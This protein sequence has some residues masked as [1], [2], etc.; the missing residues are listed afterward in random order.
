MTRVTNIVTKPRGAVWPFRSRVSYNLHRRK[1]ARARRRHLGAWIPGCHLYLH[2][3]VT[4]YLYTRHRARGYGYH[5]MQPPA[6]AATVPAACPARCRTRILPAAHTT[7][8]RLP[9]ASA[10][11]TFTPPQNTLRPLRPPYHTPPCTLLVIATTF[12]HPSYTTTQLPLPRDTAHTTH[13][14]HARI[15]THC[16]ARRTHIRTRTRFTTPTHYHLPHTGFLPTRDT[17]HHTTCH[18]SLGSHA[19]R[20]VSRCHV[21]ILP[22]ALRAARHARSPRGPP[23]PAPRVP[24]NTTPARGCCF[25]RIRDQLILLTG[26]VNALS[27]VPLPRNAAFLRARVPHLPPFA[28]PHVYTMLYSALPPLSPR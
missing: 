21:A 25:T 19:D 27:F 4:A 1:P 17:C 10:A 20:V 23:P 18:T 11:T 9:H 16:R 13:T 28:T 26:R 6:R 22:R 15:H 5:A 14:H 7:P 3:T 24:V 12:P 8:L 2:T